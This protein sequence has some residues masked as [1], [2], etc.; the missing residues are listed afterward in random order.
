LKPI[1]SIK[2]TIPTTLRQVDIQIPGKNLVIVGANGSGKTSFLRGV[3]TVLRQNIANG[4]IRNRVHFTDAI[5]ERLS[6]IDQ[7]TDQSIIMMHNSVITEMKDQLEEMQKPFSIEYH[8]SNIFINEYKDKHS[9]VLFFEASRQSTI[10]RPQNAGPSKLDKALL[11]QQGVGGTLEQHLVNLKVRLALTPND[12]NR[13]LEINNWFDK[14][15]KDLRYLFEDES[16]SMTFEPD[17]MRFK[18][19]QDHKATYDMQSLSSGYQA[20]FSIFSELIMRGEYLRSTPLDMRGV[21]IIDEIDVHLHI[22]LQ[23]KI[24]PFLS[25]SFPNMQ[26]IVSTHSPFV[27]TS[28]DDMVIYDIS[29]GEACDDLSAY[30]IEAIVEGL[31]GVPLI[32]MPLEKLLNEL[33]E[34]TTPTSFSVFEAEKIITQLNPHRHQ[35]DPEASM[36]LEIALNKVLKAKADN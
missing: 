15:E 29:T 21:V 18:F 32:S 20:I 22:S 2:G 4:N 7:I 11:I 3:D 30:S 27:I 28:V 31:L 24:L 1:I 8:D 35:L 33:V 14:F 34:L 23:R 36:I 17:E 19:H 25:A 6:Q 10:I 9:T 12:E 16:F 5:S 13:A 26:F